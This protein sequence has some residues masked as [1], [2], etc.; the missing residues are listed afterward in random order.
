MAIELA[1]K[2]DLKL[3]E[4][5][6]INAVK[7]I[8][9]SKK[10]EAEKKWL[11]TKDLVEQF[12]IS[13]GKQQTLRNKRAIPFTKIGDTIYYSLNDIDQILEANKNL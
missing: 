1:T 6:I 9:N 3:I 5:N 10:S 2:D 4:S 8:I 13:P 7:H 12:G 11:K